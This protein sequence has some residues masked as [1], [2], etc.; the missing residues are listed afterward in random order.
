MNIY[1]RTIDGR[2][3][4][5]TGTMDMGSGHHPV[6]VE[7]RMI[8]ENPTGMM[9]ALI[10]QAGK[11]VEVFLPYPAKGNH[12]FQ[13]HVLADVPIHF[14]ARGE[15][16]YAVRDISSRFVSSQDPFAAEAALGNQELLLIRKD[17]DLFILYT[18]EVNK[19]SLVRHNYVA[20]P[21]DL[22]IGR[23]EDND[24][25]YSASMISGK[26]AVI[27]YNGK[28]WS[29]RDLDSRN[30]IFVNGY[31]IKSAELS[32][33]DEIYIYGLKIIIGCGFLSINDGNNRVYISDKK[34]RGADSTNHVMRITAS[35]SR[36][37]TNNEYNRSPR[38]RM[39]LEKKT[40][41]FELPPMAIGN[42][43][44]PM[45]MRVG[46]S[47]VMGGSAALTGNVALLAG[48]VLLP[49]LS[50]QYTKEN[51]EEYEKRRQTSYKKYLAEKKQEIQTEIE[52]EEWVLR[53][54]YPDMQEVLSYADG[55]EKLWERGKDEDDFLKLRVG[56]GQFPLKAEIKF[57]E[58]HFEM[59]E[60]DLRNKMYSLADRR[61]LLKNVPILLDLIKY[62]VVGVS[63]DRQ[64]VRDFI[65][66]L[67][68]RLS[69]LFSYDE[70]KMIVLLDED[71]FGEMEY[72]RYLPHMWDDQRNIR[73]IAVN[74]AETY[75]ISEHLQNVL[76]SDLEKARGLD[77]ILNERAY[78]IVFSLNKKLFENAAILQ[79][80]MKQKNSL[81]V[82]IFA[83]HSDLPK[84]CQVL[85]EINGEQNNKIVYVADIDHKDEAFSLDVFD[86]DD[87]AYAMRV[88]AN[89]KLRL[90]S[91]AYSLPK[92]FDFLQM[93]GVGKIEDLNILK[94]WSDSNPVKSLAAPIGIGTDGELFYLNLHE[95]FQGPH[96]LVAGMT[97]SGKSEFL[98]SYILSMA[99]NYSPEEAAFILIDY[100]GGGLAG[101]FVDD[102]KGIHLPHIVG[103]ITNLDGAAIQR[104][105][106]CIESEMKRR[107]AIFNRAKSISNQGTMD[108]YNYQKLYRQG[109]VNE[110]LP[111]LFIISDEFAEL[112]QQQPEFMDELISIAR[113]G[114][115]LGVHLILA[116]QKPAGVV[117][118]Q[119]RSNVKFKICFKVQDKQDSLDMLKRPEAAELKE[120]GRFY[121]QVGYNEFFALGQS[122]WSG[123]EYEPGDQ[124]VIKK[125]EAIQFIDRVGQ[126]I[127]SVKPEI[128]RDHT[129][130]TQLVA[131]VEDIQ[132]IAEKNQIQPLMLWKPELSRRIDMAAI[133]PPKSAAIQIPVGLLD[134]PEKQRQFP[135]ILNMNKLN[136]VLFFGESGM[137]KSTALQTVLTSVIERYT[138]EEINFYILD[139]ASRSL[140]VFKNAPHCGGMI[141]EDTKSDLFRFVRLLDTLIDE[142][143]K[144]FVQLGVDNYND[145]LSLRRI[146]M[147]FVVIDNLAGMAGTK[148]G[149]AFY[150]A[151]P[152]YLKKCTSL[153]IRFIAACTR[154]GEVLSRI[155]PEFGTNIAFAQKDKYEFG[156]AI[157]CRCS[158]VPPAI[159]GR[160]LVK[161]EDK[162]LE[163][164]AAMYKPELQSLE[165]WKEIKR[166]CDRLSPAKINDSAVKHIPE[167]NKDIEYSEL[168]SRCKPGRIPLGYSLDSAKEISLPL[169]QLSMMSVYIGNSKL[170][171]AVTAN[172]ISAAEKE[173]AKI[174]LLKKTAHSIWSR[175]IEC[176]AEGI[177]GFWKELLP[178]FHERKDLVQAYCNTNKIDKSNKQN[179]YKDTFAYTYKNTQ[180]VF[181]FI[182]SF[183]ELCK[184]ADSEALEVLAGMFSL[185]RLYNIYIIGLFYGDTAGVSSNSLYKQYNPDQIVLLFGNHLDKQPVCSLPRELIHNAPDSDAGQ[186]IMKYQEQFH[187]LYMPLTVTDDVDVDEDDRSIF[188]D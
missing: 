133:I 153:G 115:S 3:Q 174:Y 28:K 73:F 88:L 21:S 132:K 49:I 163:L 117:N 110:P 103:T 145:A 77:T 118:D 61:Y 25:V 123:A 100:K 127:Y 55:S 11:M 134:D 181:I 158:Y 109:V 167:I 176:T 58:R 4:A 42:E 81:G 44:L 138:V 54:N 1:D 90:I 48:S 164:Q 144:L 111:H 150:Y 165:R 173:N 178:L 8:I 26:H 22:F 92:S 140:A 182:E 128:K 70:V 104:N 60:D 146:P 108:I 121:L 101:A 183:S 85:L 94:R 72:I 107:Q 84:E 98:L 57:P 7:V 170:T 52:N 159:P 156:D 135:L 24:I 168:I 82:S 87:A 43:S 185:A 106:T 105:M 47:L 131:I 45:L 120:T 63:G 27:H 38:S 125:D 157:G 187:I 149:D 169:K 5:D 46:S 180:P 17:S 51:R 66:G 50:Q 93:Y 62:D 95:K 34:I 78:Y 119:I 97:G 13:R 79:T 10:S 137:G 40:I 9:A 155:R 41:S 129:Q 166:I 116:T 2:N 39:A 188:E 14:E 19:E 32:L 175:G 76:E 53:H 177:T 69:I 124:V 71:D 89:T 99:I 152:T 80:V 114:R 91:Q 184:N 171:R 142:R 126:E 154:P 83:A 74:D 179:L 147:I 86:K 33:G 161:Y 143:T 96:G 12:Y 113:I 102:K 35:E 20:L 130:K 136:H 122:A 160:G 56:Y 186:F 59:E 172:L 162:P 30:G 141:T 29:V 151:L 37:F 68:M 139:F 23:N 75:Q 31:R 65:N 36:D 148:D 15:K 67:I 112:K 18:E 6:S 64:S 16:W